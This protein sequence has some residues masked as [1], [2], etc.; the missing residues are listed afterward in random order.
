MVAM[1]TMSKRITWVDSSRLRVDRLSACRARPFNGRPVSLS[2]CESS[3]ICLF[4][5]D[6]SDR[7]PSPGPAELKSDGA[8]EYSAATALPTA[9]SDPQLRRNTAVT[10]R[11][12][13]PAKNQLRLRHQPKENQHIE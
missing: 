13:W 3:S 2:P 1:V 10:N 4:A 11:K 5:A 12:Q 9:F 7:V 8:L 6:A